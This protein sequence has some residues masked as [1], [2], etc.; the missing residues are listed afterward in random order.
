VGAL[1]AALQWAPPAPS[2]WFSASNA[3]RV[4]SAYLEL[5]ADQNGMLSPAELGAYSGRLYTSAFV[6]RLFQECHTYASSARDALTGAPVAEIDYK[7]YLEVVLASENRGALPSQRFFFK[8]L[9]VGK[10]GCFGLREIQYF[11]GAVQARLRALGQDTVDA[12][13]VA[14]E[15]LDMLR[16][17][18]PGVVTFEDLRRSKMGGIVCS[19]LMDASAFVAYD[20]R[21]ELGTQV[22]EDA[23]DAE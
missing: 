21:E 16:P 8:L 10:R 4:Y 1:L 2:N 22:G 20:R 3:L 7:T 13:N 19:M 23:S 11:Y 14:D 6:S 5:D 12:G 9:D 18:T 17:A 15:V